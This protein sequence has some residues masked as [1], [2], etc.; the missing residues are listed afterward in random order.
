[1]KAKLVNENIDS[2]LN[3]SPMYHQSTNIPV[4]SKIK[5]LKPWWSIDCDGPYAWTLE[6]AEELADDYGEDIYI[7]TVKADRAIV[8]ANM[9]QNMAAKANS[10]AV[11]DPL[12]FKVIAVIRGE[13]Q[14]DSFDFF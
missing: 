9:V 12:D 11:D 3:E 5:V 7:N 10:D 4:G 13:V 6:D 14:F 2:F 8:A 1:M